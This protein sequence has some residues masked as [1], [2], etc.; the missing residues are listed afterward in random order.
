MARLKNILNAKVIALVQL[1]KARKKEK[2][3]QKQKR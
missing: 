1:K 2:K 3:K